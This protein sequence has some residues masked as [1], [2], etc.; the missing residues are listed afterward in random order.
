MVENGQVE[1]KQM[2]EVGVVVL[3]LATS[4]SE[5]EVS[6]IGRYVTVISRDIR[7]YCG[8]FV[9]PSHT[10]HGWSPCGKIV[11]EVET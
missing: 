1:K 11:Q 10:V 8:H 4:H 6:K 3:G 2:V 7:M 9:G 5:S